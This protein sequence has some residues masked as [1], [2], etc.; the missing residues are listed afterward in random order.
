LPRE[1]PDRIANRQARNEVVRLLH[2]N[3]QHFARERDALPPGA[4]AK[5][6]ETRTQGLSAVLMC[7]DDA[8]RDGG[9]T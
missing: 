5:L 4:V 7:P 8:V 1:Q 6:A 2:E 9:A 3:V